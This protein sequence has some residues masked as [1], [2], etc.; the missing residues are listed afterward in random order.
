[1]A[2]GSFL[3]AEGNRDRKVDWSQIMR[4]LEWLLKNP[5]F[6]AIGSGSRKG[7]VQYNDTIRAKLKSLINTRWKLVWNR[8]K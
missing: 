1:M 2:G 6:S 8:E 7:S 4:G 5:N 3:E